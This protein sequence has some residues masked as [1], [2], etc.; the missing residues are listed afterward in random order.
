MSS[1]D[2]RDFTSGAAKS[3][4]ADF[5]AG[6]STYVPLHRIDR[7]QIAPSDDLVRAAVFAADASAHVLFA[8]PASSPDVNRNHVASLQVANQGGTAVLLGLYDGSPG[9]PDVGMAF[10]YVPANSSVCVV[11]QAPLRGSAGNAIYFKASAT[12]SLV[13]SAQGYVWS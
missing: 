5:D 1:I 9:S 2:V 11:F 8:A 4:K 13:V 12:S 3:V 10:V 7:F 6:D